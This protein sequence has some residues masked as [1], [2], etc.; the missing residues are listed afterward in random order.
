MDFEAMKL[1]MAPLM[2]QNAHVIIKSSSYTTNFKIKKRVTQKY[3]LHFGT[4][5][6]CG[7]DLGHLYNTESIL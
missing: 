3:M 4:K 5:S 7:L 2:S 6:I 1:N